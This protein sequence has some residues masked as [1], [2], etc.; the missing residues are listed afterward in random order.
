MHCEV[1]GF[2][3]SQ[4]RQLRLFALIQQNANVQRVDAELTSFENIEAWHVRCNEVIACNTSQ[5]LSLYHQAHVDS[6][7]HQGVERVKHS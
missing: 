6:L 2:L 1:L 7:K 5:L 3:A 4:I